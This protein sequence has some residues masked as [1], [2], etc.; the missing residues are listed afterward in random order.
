MQKQARHHETLKGHRPQGPFKHYWGEGSRYVGDD[1]PFSLF[2]ATGIPF[3]VTDSVSEEGWTFL[4]DADAQ[5]LAGSSGAAAKRRLVCRPGAEGASGDLRAVDETLDAL[6]P[7]KHQVIEAGL[8][9]PYVVEDLPVVCAWYPSAKS[10]L[11]WNL[12]GEGV[13]LR[14]QWD[15]KTVPIEVDALDTALISA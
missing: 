15:G 9:V 7:L 11:L 8:D 6:W 1:Q 3:E 5:N 12:T 14:L 10:V 2:L 4:A 13:S